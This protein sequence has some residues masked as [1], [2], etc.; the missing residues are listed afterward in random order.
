MRAATPLLWRAG[1]AAAVFTWTSA[2]SGAA[3]LPPGRPTE[4]GRGGTTPP[5]PPSPPL[6]V[7]P[8]APAPTA[9]PAAPPDTS[10]LDALRAAGVTAEPAPQPKPDDQSCQIEVPVRLTALSLPGGKNSV[11]MPDAPVVA[12]RFA[13]PFAD[14]LSDIAVPVLGTARGT[15]LKAVRTGP[16]FECRSR[17]RQEGAKPSAHGIGLAIDIAAFEFATGPALTVKPDG[18]SAMDG[19]ALGGVR[20]AACGWF[21]T[22]LGPGSDPYHGDHLHLDI[23]QHGSS[24]RYRICQ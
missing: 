1:L 2:L 4:F 11:A 23:Q 16:G 15:P 6:P 17:N 24:D 8:A 18:H 7:P 5:T 10:C 9:T 19:A 21:T 20:Q 14:W 3:P 13:R 12:C 22:V